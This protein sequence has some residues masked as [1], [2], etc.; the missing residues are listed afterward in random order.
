MGRTVEKFDAETE[1]FPIDATLRDAV[2]AP[3]RRAPFSPL[4][5]R[6]GFVYDV[7]DRGDR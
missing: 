5:V 4:K 7:G 2:R 6:A 3:R 1:F